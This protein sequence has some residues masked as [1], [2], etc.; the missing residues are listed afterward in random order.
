MEM[1][2]EEIHPSDFTRIPWFREVIK[3]LP[4][5]IRVCGEHGEAVHIEESDFSSKPGPSAPFGKA[6]W[7]G[8]S[9][10]A[11]HRVMAAVNK[12]LEEIDRAKQTYQ[13]ELAASLEPKHNGAIVAI[14]LGT[15]D[16]FVG[17]DE[18]DA[19][20]K[21]RAAGHEGTLFFL[22]VG[23]PYAHRLVTPRR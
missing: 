12:T 16:Y 7:V 6:Y 4:E 10:E 21:A 23:S 15:N 14:E 9:K 11:I 5:E 19:S 13:L 1:V 18:V 8:C 3:T 22:R 2:Q 17:N 20:E